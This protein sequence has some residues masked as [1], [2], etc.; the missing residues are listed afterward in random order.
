MANKKKELKRDYLQNH[1]PMGIYQIRN[2]ANAKIL[3]GAALNLR[4]AL[5]GSKVQLKAGNYSNKSLQS[6]W[7]EFGTDNFTF[8]I[9]D[10]LAAT[11]GPGHD[12]RADLASLEEL[13]L[14]RLQPYGE[15][16]YN[17]KKKDTEEKLR[18]IAQN[19]LSKV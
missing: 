4:G 10:E 14:E 5:N 8:E 2:T 11:E 9:L 16:G 13:W 19:R 17:T 7:N 18:L 3:V 12:Y 6:E 1:T 15:R